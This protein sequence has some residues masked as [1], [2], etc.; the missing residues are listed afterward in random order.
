MKIFSGPVF[1]DDYWMAAVETINLTV[2]TTRACLADES[3]GM[4]V[5]DTPKI[6]RVTGEHSQ[7]RGFAFA[8]GIFY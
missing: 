8:I 2:S 5:I 1:R 3:F 6:D 4:E 7:I